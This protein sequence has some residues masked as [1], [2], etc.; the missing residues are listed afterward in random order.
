MVIQEKE[1]EWVGLIGQEKVAIGWLRKS[2]RKKQKPRRGA[3]SVKELGGLESSTGPV[4]RHQLVAGRKQRQQ[5]RQRA[6]QRYDELL[7]FTS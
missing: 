1:G 6:R 3:R 7:F 4:Q 2:R 5:Q